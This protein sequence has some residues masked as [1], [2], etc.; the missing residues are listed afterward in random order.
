MTKATKPARKGRI[1]RHS[2]FRGRVYKASHRY[3]G[4]VSEIGHRKFEQA[5]KQLAEEYRYEMER[6]APPVSDSDTMEF[7][8]RGVED[9]RKYLKKLKRRGG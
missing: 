1:G 6:E 2:I 4:N 3:Q 9:T 8:A 7:L 5:R